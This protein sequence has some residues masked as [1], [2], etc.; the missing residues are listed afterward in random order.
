MALA[1]EKS[2]AV[3]IAKEWGKLVQDYTDCEL[4]KASDRLYAIEGVVDL[5][6]KAFHDTYIFGLWRTELAR[7]LGFYVKCPR[8]DLPSHY[9]APSWSWASLQSPVE[10]EPHSCWPDTTEHVSV[11]DLSLTDGTL[12]LRGPLFTAKIEKGSRYNLVSL[13]SDNARIPAKIFPDRVGEQVNMP[14]IIT[15]LPLISHWSISG[16]M[17]GLGCLVLEPILV[18]VSRYYRRI[19]Y[20]KFDQGQD[21]AFFGMTVLADGSA[22]IG[23]SAPSVISLM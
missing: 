9:V 5:F 11:L 14:E 3:E 1:S 12:T 7:Q 4:T 13:V 19:A 22:K 2:P 16:P 18:T 15:L 17:T 8:K 6:R 10:F 20:I 21:L 23:K